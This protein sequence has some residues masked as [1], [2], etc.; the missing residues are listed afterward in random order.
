MRNL[1]GFRRVTSRRFFLQTHNE[2]C[3]GKFEEVEHH[4]RGRR[5]VCPK[6]QAS[7][8][9]WGLTQDKCEGLLPDSTQ[10]GESRRAWEPS[11]VRCECCEHEFSTGI[12]GHVRCPSC[13][14]MVDP[15]MDRFKSQHKIRGDSE[16]MYNKPIIGKPEYIR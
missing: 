8:V 13:G 16:N 2:N 1:K 3:D 10:K 7:I 6:C 9:H 5:F 11:L 4:G 14:H 12:D 15:L